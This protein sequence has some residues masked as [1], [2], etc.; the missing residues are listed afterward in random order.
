MNLAQSDGKSAVIPSQ[1]LFLV[2]YDDHP[3]DLQQLMHTINIEGKTGIVWNLARGFMLNHHSKRYA[4]SDNQSD[5]GLSDPKEAIRFIINKAQNEVY[6]VLEDFHHLIG[7]EESIHPDVG[8]IRSMIKEMGRSLT[9]RK[10]KVFFLVPSSYELPAEMGPFFHL[11]SGPKKT[12]KGFLKKY[13]MLLTEENFIMGSKPVIGA[14]AQIERVIQILSQMETNNPLLI[15]HPGVGKSAVV[16]GFAKALFEGR[17]PAHLKERMLYLISLN[18]L[19]SWT[20]YRG[21]FEERLEGLM[22]EV[23]QNKD[24]IIIFIDEIHTLLNAGSAEGSIGAG[25]ALKPV[26]ARGEFPCIGA[27]TFEGAEHLF[28]DRALG[29]R[30]KKV[31]IKEP[32]ADEAFRILKGI[33]VCFEKHH[34]LKI[35]DRALMSAVYSSLKYLPDEYLPGKAIALLDAAAAYCS[36]KGIDRVKEEDIMLEIERIQES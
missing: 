30:F 10:E 26:L 11:P 1:R 21:E 3:V 23:L 7:K 4:L 19:V 22:E 29:R 27:T 34:C 12:T 9:G 31:I 36:M 17:V 24:R 35:D 6:Y 5:S 25:D 2:H 32:S 20:K 8:E 33:A 18:G 28:L 15:G 16:E 13:G 14:E